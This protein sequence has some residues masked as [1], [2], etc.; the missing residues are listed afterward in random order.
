MSQAGRD[1]YAV[2]GVPADASER[3]LRRA[4]R[5]KMRENH[6]D[7]GGDAAAFSLVQW[8]WDQVGTSE[9]R[10]SYDSARRTGTA[11]S[12]GAS[13]SGRPDAGDRVW[14]AGA[15]TS[16]SEPSR[17]R[18]HG[19]PGGWYRQRYLDMIREWVGRGVDL[20]DPYDSE[21]TERA[22]WDIRH[23]LADAIAEEETAK[24]LAT[25]NSG[26]TLWHDVAIPP[27]FASGRGPNKIDHIAL[28]PSG[29][30]AIQ[31]EDWLETVQVGGRDL[32]SSALSAKERPMKD[33]SRRAAVAR[34]WGVSFTGLLIV[35]PDADLEED[36][37]VVGRPRSPAR[38]AVRRSMISTVVGSGLPGIPGLPDDVVFEWRT[39][40]QRA[41][42]FI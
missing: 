31:S 23:V 42:R 3:D 39:R 37:H 7:L 35:L 41:I 40:L 2:L 33:L 29:L 38:F 5:R 19:H 6:P 34:S 18:A 14:S 22:P 27:R 25:L 16:R 28:G 30:F 20:P 1:A 8:A 13:G 21:L 26:V 4:Y 32:L 11:S 9:A 10:A 24:S 36:L 15:T 17:A 12:T